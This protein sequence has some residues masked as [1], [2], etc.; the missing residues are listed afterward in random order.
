MS[1]LTKLCGS[2][3]LIISFG[4]MGRHNGEYKFDF[5]THLT[6]HNS[7]CDL[8]FYK[9]PI[10]SWYH[11]GIDGIT[12][13]IDETKDYI[14]KKITSGNY[15]K[16]IFIGSSAG[17]YAAILFG[18]LCNVSN[19]IAFIPQTN[20]HDIITCTLLEHTALNLRDILT[21]NSEY[22]DLKN[23][24][25]KHTKYTLFGV[26][27][28]VDSSDIHCIS[29]CKNISHYKNVVI[30]ARKNPDIRPLRNNGQLKIILDSI[31]NT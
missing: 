7:N 21:K 16:T 22:I 9:D 20:L 17:G 28:L 31:I 13:N 15:E 24:I 25:N 4:G 30:K 6:N 11:K 10:A 12:T 26:H 8:I 18:S 29:H 1:E 2:K 14:N 5:V 19:V 23:I 27:S 3:I